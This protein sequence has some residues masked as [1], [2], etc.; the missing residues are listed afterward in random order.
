M[1]MDTTLLKREAREAHRL[2]ADAIRSIGDAD[3]CLFDD[4]DLHGEVEELLDKARS[5]LHKA[6]GQIERCHG[7]A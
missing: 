2:L 6:R 1:S 7:N 3:A 5:L 4:T